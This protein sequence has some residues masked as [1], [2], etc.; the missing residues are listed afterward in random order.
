MLMLPEQVREERPDLCLGQRDCRYDEGSLQESE[1]MAENAALHPRA[2]VQT[3]CDDDYAS[4][5]VGRH[6]RATQCDWRPDHRQVYA[7]RISTP[8][9]RRTCCARA[10]SQL[11]CES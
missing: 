4:R 5:P 9:T 2:A 3:C 7:R 6:A 10:E 8:G 11:A 1:P